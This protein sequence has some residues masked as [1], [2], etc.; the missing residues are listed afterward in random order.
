MEHQN[1]SQERLIKPEI[2]L[3]VIIDEKEYTLSE[4]N[5]DDWVLY[6][7]RVDGSAETLTLTTLEVEAY[8]N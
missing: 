5:D 2:G 3:S 4:H 8:L 7:E 6:R 1:K